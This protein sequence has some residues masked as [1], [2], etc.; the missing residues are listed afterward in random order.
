[1]VTKVLNKAL[2]RI[3]HASTG[4]SKFFSN[5]IGRDARKGTVW[6]PRGNVKL[7]L[8]E[9]TELGQHL[10]VGGIDSTRDVV[11]LVLTAEGYLRQQSGHLRD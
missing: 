3:D 4:N 7:T 10:L 11:D 9:P 5:T 2:E 6:G 1:M 8:R